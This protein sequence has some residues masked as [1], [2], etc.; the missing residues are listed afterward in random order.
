MFDANMT[1]FSRIDVTI[2]DI[3]FNDTSIKTQMLHPNGIP[4]MAQEKR[5]LFSYLL[6]YGNVALLV[7]LWLTSQ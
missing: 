5:V 7:I 4:S 1:K 3:F 2:D 6:Y